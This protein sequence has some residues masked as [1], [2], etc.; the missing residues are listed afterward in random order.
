MIAETKC[1]LH[2]KSCFSVEIKYKIWK[3]LELKWLESVLSELH[4]P[5]TRG[6]R[7]RYSW[8]RLPPQGTY[9]GIG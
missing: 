1:L 7:I 5:A 8:T 9:G 6:K 4:N 2:S 3:I